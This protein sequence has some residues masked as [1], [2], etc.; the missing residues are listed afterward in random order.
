MDFSLDF[1]GLADIARDLEALSRAENNKVLRDATRAGAEVMRDAVVERAP[2]RTGKLK[3]N[4]VVLTSVQSVGGNYLG[5][6]IRGRNLRTGNSDNSMKASDPRNA[7]YWRFVELG[8]INMPAHP[9]IRPAFDTTEEL[10]AQVAIQ[11]M[12]QAIDEVLSK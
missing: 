1:S 5:V 7:F 12:N 6:H 9:F 11:R 8:T 2:E 4:V 3:K 10:A